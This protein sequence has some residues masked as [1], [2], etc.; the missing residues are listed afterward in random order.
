[1]N[2]AALYQSEG[3]L[4][5]AYKF[6]EQSLH[7]A[8]KI[9][10]HYLTANLL[11]NLANLYILFGAAPEARTVLDES[12]QIATQHQLPYWLAYNEI[13]RGDLAFLQNNFSSASTC[14]HK[15]FGLFEKQKLK[16]EQAIVTNNLFELG[17][18]SQVS[19]QE[20]EKLGHTP[21]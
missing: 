3:K 17:F 13:L 8:K 1:M 16:R 15:A 7:L 5:D 21:S 12:M 11:S 9:N 6:Y 20:L 10:H 2:L 14:Y 18:Y 19:V 4:S